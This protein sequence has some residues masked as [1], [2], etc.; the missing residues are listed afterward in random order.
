MHRL[1]LNHRVVAVGALVVGVVVGCGSAGEELPPPLTP[2]SDA[3][4]TRPDSGAPDDAG[5]RDGSGGA[6][7]SGE[8]GTERV[9][10]CD[11]SA[12]PNKDV[13]SFA[14]GMPTDWSAVVSAGDTVDFQPCPGGVPGTCLH[15]KTLETS[16]PGA[17]IQR[18]YSVGAPQ[19]L[20]QC[21]FVYVDVPDPPTG[22]F[23]SLTLSRFERDSS[24]GMWVE[25]YPKNVAGGD[26]LL[27]GRA[28]NLGV[29]K[30]AQWTTKTPPQ[31]KW[32]RIV[33]ETTFSSSTPGAVV[34]SVDGEE[35]KTAP[36]VLFGWNQPTATFGLGLDG[37]KVAA[38]AWFYDAR[39]GWD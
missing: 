35:H 29:I 5:P 30:E 16:L 13:V 32:Q 15:A 7:D 10:S 2:A 23:P 19:K 28:A 38:E 3:G 9:P 8:G 17:R 39:V 22:R 25:L 26:W 21:F 34:L 33:L 4:F 24:M 12:F 14:S 27:T 11:L 1:V 18:S 20:R 6:T 36:Q 31:K 37:L